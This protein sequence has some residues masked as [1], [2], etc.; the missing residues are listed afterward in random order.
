MNQYRN[1]LDQRLK[2]DYEQNP[3]SRR[4]F[5]R[6]F[7]FAVASNSMDNEE[8]SIEFTS[9]P[10]APP[11]ASKAEAASRGLGGGRGRRSLAARPKQ[12][13]RAAPEES[14]AGKEVRNSLGRVQN[15]VASVDKR[16]E[17]DELYF[18]GEQ[19]KKD[20]TQVRQYYQRTKPTQEWVENNY[21]QVTAK[22]QNPQ[23]MR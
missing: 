4:K 5:D 21:Y 18:D 12:K 8:K 9:E 11:S 20:R 1:R 17:S 19:L 13:S 16:G 2:D 23:L 3:T 22:Q 14:V 15:E 7:D 6:F 10:M